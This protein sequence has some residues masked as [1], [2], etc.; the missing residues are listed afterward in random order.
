MNMLLAGYFAF[1]G[2]FALAATVDP[3]LVELLGSGVSAKED[4]DSFDAPRGEGGMFPRAGMGCPCWQGRERACL[5][6][7]LVVVGLASLPS[8]RTESSSSMPRSTP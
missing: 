6:G 1:I 3:I 2:A 7:S 5:G 8:L 4:Q